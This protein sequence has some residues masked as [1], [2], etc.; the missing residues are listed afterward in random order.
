MGLGT[1]MFV[2]ISFAPYP[3]SLYVLRMFHFLFLL[4]TNTA[5]C[6][7]TARVLPGGPDS[8]FMMSVS[9]GNNS[10]GAEKVTRC[11]NGPVNS[12]KTYKLL[13][14]CWYVLGFIPI[15]KK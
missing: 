8:Q 2:S 1:Q 9:L 6:F 14:L 4:S 10:T 15:Y 12:L 3:H 13:A 11:F 7:F 5:Y